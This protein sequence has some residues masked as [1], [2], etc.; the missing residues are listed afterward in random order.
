MKDTSFNLKDVL[1]EYDLKF[2]EEKKL[3][4]SYGIEFLEHHEETT[5]KNANTIFSDVRLQKLFDLIMTEGIENKA[6][7][8]FIH[9]EEKFGIVRYRVGR[10]MIPYRIIHRGATESLITYIRKLTE[11]NPEHI[12]APNG[13][14]FQ[15]KIEKTT[16]TERAS[17]VPYDCRIQ[18]NPSNYGSVTSIR[19]FYPENLELTVKDLGFTDL[20]TYNYNQALKLRE[21]LII[22]SGPTGSGKA[23]DVNTDIPMF[24][25]GFNKLKD[26][27]IG[28][29]ILDDKGNP[30]KV[31]NIFYHE[32]KESLKLT[33]SDKL[34]VI[35]DKEHNW[36]VYE[37][38]LKSPKKVTTDYIYNN[39][40]LNKYYFETVKEPVKYEHKLNSNQSFEQ[41]M[42]LGFSEEPIISDNIKNLHNR[43]KIKYNCPNSD[44]Y[45]TIEEYLYSSVRDRVD[46]LRGLVE[47]HG[48]IKN[49][50]IC[51]YTKDCEFK[52][53]VKQLMESLGHIVNIL[54]EDDY[55]VIY[56]EIKNYKNRYLP[57]DS[58]NFRELV[59]IEKVTNR[60]TICL[61]VDSDS[62]LFLCTKSYLPTHNT[63]TE[64]V[65]IK[66]ILKDS[67]FTS[68]ILTVED[69]IE[70]RIAGIVQTSVDELNGYTFA[71]ATKSFLRMNPDVML[72]GEVRDNDTAKTATRAS[73]SGHLTLTTIH[74]NSTLEVLDVLKQY[75]VHPNDIKNAVK[76][77]IFQ[78][79]EDRLCPKCREIKILNSHQKNWIDRKLMNKEELATVYVHKEHGCDYCNHTGYKGK[80]LLNEMLV[81]NFEFRVLRDTY[82]S[83][84]DGLKRALINSEENIYYP[85]EWDIHRRIKE[86][87]IDFE[88][89]TRLIH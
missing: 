7:D 66:Q 86:G 54:K 29:I 65:G 41:G 63:T 83:D 33:F 87:E 56:F 28:D 27:N 32:N 21:G 45:K 72:I 43:L 81:S 50:L 23:L 76:L 10:S 25:G 38:C 14:N 18:F 20:V 31:L 46:L 26:I 40:H 73:T 17:I 55:Y 75:G 49:G 11:T 44:K 52:K 16:L 2:D 79:L 85:I 69:P 70:T 42:C 74:A 51:Y 34:E 39:F 84:I 13:A 12:K 58:I 4:V 24:Q 53:I 62:H 19:V 67:N 71:E 80:I 59:S 1:K 77:I 36:M 88:T 3:D 35:S 37:N 22:L 60:D 47:S 61:T 64:Y 89:A 57:S 6:T 15:F 8:I 30:T 78:T 82:E 48:R 5:F 9:P 68:N